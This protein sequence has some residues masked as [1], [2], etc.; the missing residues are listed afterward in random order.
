MRVHLA[1][2]CAA[3]AG[4]TLVGAS[5]SV[6]PFSIHV[7]RYTGLVSLFQAKLLRLVPVTFT[8][9]VTGWSARGKVGLVV[10][11]WARAKLQANKKTGKNDNLTVLY[12][13]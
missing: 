5:I 1:A 11:V 2:A 9:M 10:T 8:V 6:A 3:V 7:H 12:L 13:K 4:F